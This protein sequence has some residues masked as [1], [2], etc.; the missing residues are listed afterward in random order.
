MSNVK[1]NT[2]KPKRDK[3]T[4]LLLIGE[5]GKFIFFLVLFVLSAVPH[6]WYLNIADNMLLVWKVQFS[7]SITVS[8]HFFFVKMTQIPARP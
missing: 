3:Y 6:N 4:W 5:K 8:K 1:A 7:L 2:E